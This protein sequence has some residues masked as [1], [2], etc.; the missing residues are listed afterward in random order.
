MA[1]QRS[2]FQHFVLARFFP[3]A[4]PTHRLEQWTVESSQVANSEAAAKDLAWD[5]WRAPFRG[6][7]SF[8]QKRHETSWLLFPVCLDA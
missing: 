1:L 2:R 4:N 5:V 6:D 3:L 7:Q 8:G